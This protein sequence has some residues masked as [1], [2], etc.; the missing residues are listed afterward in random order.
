MGDAC[1]LIGDGLLLSF[2]SLLEAYK[3]ALSA[4]SEVLSV[5]MALP[6]PGSV[7]S[8][9]PFGK[10][11]ASLDEIGPLYIAAARE[12][13]RV[14]KPGGQLMIL[15]FSKPQAPGL[16]PIYDAYSFGVLMCEVWSDGAVPYADMHS[17][18]DVA[19]AVLQSGEIGRASCRE[20]VSS[21]V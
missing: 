14:L 6:M 18:A 2:K 13:D 4:V 15:E 8:N 7:V 9:P 12:W 21:P 5:A 1:A 16:A 19:M 11:L 3:E 10:Q 17:V 20:R